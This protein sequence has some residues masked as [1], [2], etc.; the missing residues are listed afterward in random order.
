MRMAGEPAK[1]LA[2]L[3]ELATEQ[4]LSQTWKAIKIAGELR[5]LDELDRAE[6]IEVGHPSCCHSH[7]VDRSK[8]ARRATDKQ[9]ID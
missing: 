7:G 3:R 1:A 5:Q 6:C 8:A 4:V 9:G 2:R